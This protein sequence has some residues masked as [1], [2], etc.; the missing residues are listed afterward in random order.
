MNA[1]VLDTSALIAFVFEEPGTDEVETWLDKGAAASSVVLQELLTRL[2]REGFDRGDADEAVENL[3]LS[4]FDHT[5]ELA[6]AAAN[7]YPVT[8]R[9]GLSHGDRSCLALAAA[10]GVPAVTAD[11]E[12]A[13]VGI[14]LGASVELIR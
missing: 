14:E 2:L 12:W 8:R 4:L 3:G 9:F 6:A 1:A 7:L 13:S 10:L 5:P 11:R